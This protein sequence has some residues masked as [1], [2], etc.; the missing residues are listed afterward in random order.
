MTKYGSFYEKNLWSN[1]EY[2]ASRFD[3][4]KDENI[5]CLVT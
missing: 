5:T 4:S 1:K 3:V 2:K